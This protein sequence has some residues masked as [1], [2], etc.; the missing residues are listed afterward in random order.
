[1]PQPIQYAEYKEL[2][3]ILER[4]NPEHSYEDLMKKEE[5]VLDT[6]N[7]VVKYYT[8]FDSMNK[9]FINQRLSVIIHRFFSTWLDI[10]KDVLNKQDLKTTFTKDDRIF[11]VGMMLILL[12]VFLYVVRNLS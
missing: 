4:S 8:D 11:Y 5:K 10:I 1:M 2:V 3:D 6:V 12:S 9:E 7:N